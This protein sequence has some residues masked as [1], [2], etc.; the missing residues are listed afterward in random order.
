MSSD[1]QETRLKVGIVLGIAGCVGVL[2]WQ[3]IGGGEK[4]YNAQ[5]HKLIDAEQ[6]KLADCRASKSEAECRTIILSLNALLPRAGKPL[7]R[8]PP[9]EDEEGRLALSDRYI[10]NTHIGI[11][12]WPADQT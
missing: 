8:V 4:D 9:Q 10:A 12:F 11:N 6:K 1:S 2:A 5:I 7:L 3:F